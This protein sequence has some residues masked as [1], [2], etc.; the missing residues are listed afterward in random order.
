M[1]PFEV[2]SMGNISDFHLEPSILHFFQVSRDN[3]QNVRKIGS[4]NQN[5]IILDVLA[6][7]S[8]PGAYFSKLFFVLKPWVQAGRFFRTYKGVL[9]FKKM[10]KMQVRGLQIKI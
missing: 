7:I 5:C 4:P 9:E 6:N 1:E 3:K 10:K 2:L 8:G